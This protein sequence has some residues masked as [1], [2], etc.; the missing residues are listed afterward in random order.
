MPCLQVLNALEEIQERHDAVREIEK[1][2]LDLHQVF[3]DLKFKSWD[4]GL[5]FFMTLHHFVF[6]C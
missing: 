2:L 6:W 1:K 5:T 4:W 3:L